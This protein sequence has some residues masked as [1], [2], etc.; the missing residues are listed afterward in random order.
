MFENKEGG[1]FRWVG[2]A[3]GKQIGFLAIWLQWIETIFWFCTIIIFGSVCIAFIGT[4]SLRDVSVSNN[5][6]YVLIIGLI[7]FWF[8]TFISLKGTGWV[9]IFAKIG[10][11]L[12]TIIPTIILV[13]LAILYLSFGGKSEMDFD[14][15]IFPELKGFNSF[16][17][18][19][20]VFLYF[21]G[22]E[23]SGLRINELKNSNKNYPRAVFISTIIIVLIFI[24][25]TYAIAVIIP[26][27]DISLTQSVLVGF[28][29]YLRFLNLHKL[30]PIISILLTLDRKSVV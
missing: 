6:I 14:A 23:I 16:V 8:I 24:L 13:I 1:I 22:M 4:D 21:A 5:K 19:I 18:A 29:D 17:L 26:Q 12:G 9:N 27:K 25:G 3:F 15:R 30:T 10:G 20:S 7:L 11:L 2:E 28:D